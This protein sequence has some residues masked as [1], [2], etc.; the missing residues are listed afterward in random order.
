MNKIIDVEGLK[1]NHDY[2]GGDN[3]QTLLELVS[4]WH[5]NIFVF[6]VVWIQPNEEN[7]FVLMQSV[8]IVITTTVLQKRLK[9]G[10]WLSSN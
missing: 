4:K 5:C 7:N 10:I 6:N 2:F 3:L 8:R 9:T 1:A